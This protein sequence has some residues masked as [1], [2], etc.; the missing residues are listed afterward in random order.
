MLGWLAT[1][2][3]DDWGR[4]VNLDP[5]RQLLIRTSR[6]PARFHRP[7]ENIQG[8]YIGPRVAHRHFKMFKVK[9]RILYNKSKIIHLQCKECPR[10]L[11]RFL[12][13]SNTKQRLKMTAIRK[14]FVNLGRF[15]YLEDAK[16]IMHYNFITCNSPLRFISK[17]LLTI[18][19]TRTRRYQCL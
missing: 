11:G 2:L 8:P 16:H 12:K 6:Y 13:G 9:Q 19:K 17:N 7:D 18:R 5:D 4:A 10:F 14:G 3:S 1:V 15:F